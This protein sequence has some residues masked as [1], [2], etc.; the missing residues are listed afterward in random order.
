M[1]YGCFHEANIQDGGKPVHVVFKYLSRSLLYKGLEV[2]S[3]DFYYVP[4]GRRGGGRGGAGGG[5]GARERG[6]ESIF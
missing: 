4:V 6:I 1:D 3:V 5:E 2:I